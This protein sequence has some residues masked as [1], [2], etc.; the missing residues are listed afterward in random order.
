[1][2]KLPATPE[3]AP[4]HVREPTITETVRQGP[5]RALLDWLSLTATLEPASDTAQ[6][7]WVAEH[8]PDPVRRV[9]DG[10]EAVRNRYARAI[11]ENPNMRYEIPSRIALGEWVIDEEQVTGFTKPGSS[12]TIRAVL[13]YR[14]PGNGSCPEL[15]SVARATSRPGLPLLERPRPASSRRR[16]RGSPLRAGTLRGRR[17]DE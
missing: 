5:A 10:A 4:P 14:F 9:M 15:A 11:E 8:R 6:S 2:A 17:R 12:E 1:M 13:V 16:R 3:P 7:R